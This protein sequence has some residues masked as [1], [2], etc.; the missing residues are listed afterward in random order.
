MTVHSYSYVGGTDYSSITELV[1]L[2]SDPPV[3]KEEINMWLT[4]TVVQ[5]R[6]EI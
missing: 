5:L 4:V 1:F 6:E 3:N 2:S